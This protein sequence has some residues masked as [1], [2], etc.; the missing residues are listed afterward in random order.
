MVAPGGATPVQIKNPRRP[1]PA[2]YRWHEAL[3]TEGL[4]ANRDDV[5]LVVASDATIASLVDAG[6]CLLS[7][8]ELKTWLNTLLG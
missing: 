4:R 8:L 1:G 7:G 5:R 2:G 3:S 6:Q